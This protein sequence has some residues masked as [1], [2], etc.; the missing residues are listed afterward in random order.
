MQKLLIFFLIL[1]ISFVN[2]AKANEIK[3]IYKLENEIITN[4]DIINELNYLVSLNNNLK[5]LEKNKLNQIAIRS[6]IKEKIKYLE[7]KKYFKIDESTKEV[8]DIVLKELNKRLRINELENI[9]KH[10]SLYN[11]SLEQVKFKIRVELFWNKLI[12]DRYI[13][14]ISIN[15]DDLR[16]KILNDFKNKEFID[17]YYLKEILFN[18]E[19]NENLQKKYLDIKKTINNTGFENAANIYSISNTSKFGGEIGWVNK[20]QLSKKITNQL[21]KI[22]IGGL[23]NYIPVGNSYLIIK[24]DNKRKVKSEINLDEETE[25]LIQKETDRQLNQ[26]SINFFNKLK[27]NIFIYE[28]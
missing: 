28:L 8:D 16:K 19:E 21:D 4:Q 2:L 10:F 5:S 20:L 22:E 23:T 1:I 26:Y 25:I 3:I 17:E 7:L 18:L 24:L 11:L 6:I 13:N 9:E 12:F 15:K 27:K 14:K